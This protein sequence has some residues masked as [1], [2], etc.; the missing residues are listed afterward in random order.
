V[1]TG[2]F[3]DAQ[4]FAWRDH[5]LTAT[6]LHEGGRLLAWATL[7]ALLV[8]AWRAP[9]PV[10]RGVAST[11]QRTERLF[12]FAVTLAGLLLV[13]AIKRYSAT[14]CPWDMAEFGGSAHAVSHWLWG[15]PD[16]GPGHCFPSG[17]A[18]GAFAFFSQYFLWRPHRPGRARVWLLLVLGMGCL[19]GL[20]Q[21]ARGAHP[22]SHSAWSAGLCWT[23][24]VLADAWRSRKPRS[25]A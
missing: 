24:C 4:G 13:P 16:G 20:A 6:V 17:H 25:A 8:C 7:L 18:V 14:S 19:F 9:L 2:W 5:V 10:G 3:G 1:A 15:V 11:P 12:W 22:V 23:I 21:L